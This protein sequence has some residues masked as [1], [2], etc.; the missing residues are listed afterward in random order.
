MLHIYHYR[1]LFALAILSLARVLILRN[2]QMQCAC[3]RL[4]GKLAIDIGDDPLEVNV[5]EEWLPPR[6]GRSLV[7]AFDLF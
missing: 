3:T 2:L 5:S 1:Q 6:C 7:S 4:P